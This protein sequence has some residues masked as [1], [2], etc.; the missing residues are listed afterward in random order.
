MKVRTLRRKLEAV[1]AGE[2]VSLRKG[3]LLALKAL[4]ASLKV[5][6]SKSVEDL[7]EVM[8]LDIASWFKPVRQKGR[9]SAEP[10][11][12]TPEVTSLVESAR[13]VFND[14]RGFSTLLGTWKS[15][16]SVTKASL[17]A[18]YHELFGDRSVSKSKTKGQL[19]Q[20]IADERLTRAR[21][22]KA[23]RS[24]AGTAAE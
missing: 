18:L 21:H 9:T 22:T 17:I 19:L 14:D 5:N 11:P 24:L 4:F 2:D 1:V 15:D 8:G 12:R 16:R 23:V 13:R 20:D 6:D 7:C 10:S 3:D